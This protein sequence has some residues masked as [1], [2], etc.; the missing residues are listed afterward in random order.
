MPLQNAVVDDV[1]NVLADVADDVL[2]DDADDVVVSVAVVV[3]VTVVDV[4]V[5][6]VEEV[7]M[8]V[9]QSTGQVRRASSPRGPVTM[10]IPL[11]PVVH[12]SGSGL[13]LQS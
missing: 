5:D 9:P 1:D 13:P 3:D 4:A 6:V 11:L 10:H 12:L 7:P 8:H 2:V